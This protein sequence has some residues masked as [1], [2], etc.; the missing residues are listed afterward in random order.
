M[1]AKNSLILMLLFFSVIFAYR[2]GNEPQKET[3]HESVSNEKPQK[4]ARTPKNK[5]KEKV[6]FYDLPSPIEMAS[7]LNH[8][9]ALFYLEI[10]APIDNIDKYYSASS[11]A[12]MLGILGVDLGYIKNFEQPQEAIKYLAVIKRM[13][14]KIGI[15]IEETQKAFELLEQGKEEKNILLSIISETYN[16]TDEYLKKNDRNSSAAL[17]LLGGWIEAL[18][19]ATEIY[20]REPNNSEILNRI[21][22][23]K[24][25]LNT[26]VELL[27]NNQYDNIVEK[28][29]QKILVLKKI[30][31]EIEI[32]F[33]K[34]DVQIDTTK[35]VITLNNQSEIRISAEN[36]KRISDMVDKLRLTILKY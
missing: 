30:Y 7:M 3:K 2:C 28:Y 21:A 33:K 29:L 23:Q 19:I 17:I 5:T 22:E 1:K 6:I 16:T 12:L 31:D 9:K 20:K 13:T 34:S 15:P 26:I 25:S 27:S 35:K 14:K 36:V 32:K 4:K 11:Q 24:Y 8:E 10:L 18:H